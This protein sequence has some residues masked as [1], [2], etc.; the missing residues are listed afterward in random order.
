MNH[1]KSYKDAHLN[2]AKIKIESDIKDICQ[3]L[4]DPGNRFNIYTVIGHYNDILSCSIRKLKSG[5]LTPF[6]VTQVSEEILRIID[7]SNFY[8]LKHK[9]EVKLPIKDRSTIPDNWKTIKDTFL[10]KDD[11]IFEIR[12]SISY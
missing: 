12:I 5:F 1:L 9:L 8:N 3:E 6:N 10:E 11:I 4:K 7:Y 2:Q